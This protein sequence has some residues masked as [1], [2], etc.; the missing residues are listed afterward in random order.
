M[1]LG[2]VING[3]IAIYHSCPFS[4]IFKEIIMGFFDT[5]I[6]DKNWLPEY[7]HSI[8]YW[9][10]KDLGENFFT[11]KINKNGKIEIVEARY[12]NI[13][14]KPKEIKKFNFYGYINKGEKDFDWF[15][16]TGYLKNFQ[17][18][19]VEK[20]EDIKDNKVTK[21]KKSNYGIYIFN[22]FRNILVKNFFNFIF[23]GKKNKKI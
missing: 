15:E 6:I 10:T 18:Y 20:S 11:Y 21:W 16:F 4:I 14:N 13:E 7:C 9:Q 5:L 8:E 12:K 17:L 1:L 22:F 2:N 3:I 23:L 19:K